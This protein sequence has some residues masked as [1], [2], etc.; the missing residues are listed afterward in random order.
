VFAA[1]KRIT[2]P[3]VEANQALATEGN[4]YL[5]LPRT[6]RE[7]EARNQILASLAAGERGGM[8]NNHAREV[9][10]MLRLSDYT[11]WLH[12]ERRI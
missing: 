9:H 10:S 12:E 2:K 8:R 5:L 1:Y 4:G 7:V 11:R 6:P 3:F